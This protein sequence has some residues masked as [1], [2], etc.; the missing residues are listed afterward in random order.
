MDRQNLFESSYLA[1]RALTRSEMSKRF[2]VSF[3]GEEGS[4]FGGVRREWYHLITLEMT[5]PEYGIL[6]PSAGDPY[7]S[8]AALVPLAS[9][10][11]PGGAER[12]SHFGQGGRE[13]GGLKTKGGPG[14]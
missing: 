1:I 4:D 2:Q 7:R 10:C 3:L 13:G 14:C 8:A 12:H 9:H 5:K 6:E 11:A